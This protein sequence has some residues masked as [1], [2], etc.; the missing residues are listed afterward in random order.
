MVSKIGSSLKRFFQPLLNIMASPA[1]RSIFSDMPVDITM[2]EHLV[3]ASALS[4]SPNSFD[5]NPENY[6]VIELRIYKS[7][8]SPFHEF[9]VAVVTRPES[10]RTILLRLEHTHPRPTDRDIEVQ[11]ESS[12]ENQA[13]ASALRD[14]CQESIDDRVTPQ[15]TPPDLDDDERNHC[16]GTVESNRSSQIVSTNIEPLLTRN[17]STSIF[18]RA[19]ACASSSSESISESVKLVTGTESRDIITMIPRYPDARHHDLVEVFR[20]NSFSL[21]SLAILAKIV[22]EKHPLYSLF[23]RQCFWF[24][25]LIMRVIAKKFGGEDGPQRRH[26]E[27]PSAWVR[28][29][30]S[31]YLFIKVGRVRESMVHVISDKLDIAMA[32]IQAQVRL[33]IMSPTTFP[34]F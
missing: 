30:Q 27:E 34:L 25:N 7:K 11:Q 23:H 18:Q 32:D 24:S 2:Y 5:L 22:H 21:V 8:S 15:N 13:V 10:S 31:K 14:A 3:I 4:S 19:S 33:S 26:P 20:P 17:S 28:Y 16:N 12:P 9:L 1:P 6:T 29:Q